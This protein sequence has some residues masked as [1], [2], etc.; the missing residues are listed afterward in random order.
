MTFATSLHPG[1]LWNPDPIRQSRAK[2]GR[3]DARLSVTSTEKGSFV[4][5][6]VTGAQLAFIA[7][8]ALV[9]ASAIKEI[10]EGPV[11]MF[12]P[13]AAISAACAVVKL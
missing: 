11:T 12:Q 3:A 13:L 9:E 2:R 5:A 1:G 8:K 4:A 10:S 7:I 6:L